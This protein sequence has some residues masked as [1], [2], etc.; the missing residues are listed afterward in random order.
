[1]PD[2][3]IDYSMCMSYEFFE[4]DNKEWTQDQK[5]EIYSDGLSSFLDYLNHGLTTVVTSS[6]Y[7]FQWN[8][9]GSPRL[10]HLEAMLKASREAGFTRPVFWYFGHYLQSAKGQ[11]PGNIRLYDPKVHP[12]RAEKLARTALEMDRKIFAPPL[13]FMPIDEP[14]IAARQKMTLQ[15]LEAI[16]KVPG[17]KTMSTTNIGG[18]LLDI[19]D[20]SQA[21]KILLKPGE[22]ERKSDRKVWEYNN[23]VVDCLNPCYSRY[24]YGYYTWRQDLDGMNSWG[25]GTT[26]NSRGNPYEDLDHEFTDYAI[27]YPHTGGPLATPNWE[28]LREGID[29][30]RYIYQLERRCSLHAVKNPEVVSEAMKFLDSI[31]SMCDFDD[32]SIINEYGKWTPERF[33]SLRRQIIQWIIKLDA[34]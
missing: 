27:T 2:P 33:I 28:A 19:E 31:R 6:P 22:K 1:V 23:T 24:I 3:E 34:L 32:R 9:D 14:R 4:L 10:E 25:P 12:N 13:Y 30:E 21:D 26:E 7:Y 18:K 29:D 15:L 17:A 11:H 8:R 16:K 5:Q 20:D